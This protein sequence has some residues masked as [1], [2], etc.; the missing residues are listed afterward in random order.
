MMYSSSPKLADLNERKFG[1]RHRIKGQRREEYT[2]I[3]SV[4]DRLRILKT[5]MNYAT[6]SLKSGID[7]TLLCRYVTGKVRPTY[8]RCKLLEERLLSTQDIQERLRERIS[9]KQNGYIDLHELLCDSDAL[10]W[11]SGLVRSQFR[12]EKIDRVVTAASSGITLATSTALLVGAS[13][14][15]AMH[16]RSSGPVSY[17]ESEIVSPNPSEIFSLYLPA[18]WLKRGDRVL[19]VDDVATSGRTMVGLVN[20]VER[21]GCELMGIFVL[22]S[23]SNEWKERIKN[24]LKKETKIYVMFDLAKEPILKV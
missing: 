16:T 24:L 15:Y 14:T 10:R 11:I 18:S 8:E 23:T 3:Q 5:T 22:V 6:M 2:Y 21:A 12:E 4:L 13:V 9:L 19:L 17:L 1:S 7:S 20:I